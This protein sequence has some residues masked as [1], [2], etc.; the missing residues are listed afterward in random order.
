MY[1]ER[2]KNKKKTR[3]KRIIKKQNWLK[4]NEDVEERNENGKK[5]KKKNEQEIKAV[6]EN[7][8]VK[9]K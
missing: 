6:R 7:T 8:G 5:T 3:K 9:E 4:G 1:K 2:E